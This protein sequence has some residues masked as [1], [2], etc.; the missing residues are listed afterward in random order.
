MFSYC[1]CNNK[2]LLKT[3]W[4]LALWNLTYLLHL[5]CRYMSLPA[6]CIAM[7]S[8]KHVKWRLA[9]WNL[10]S[11][12][13]VKCWRLL[14]SFSH[15]RIT[16][17]GYVTWKLVIQVTEG[18]GIAQVGMHAAKQEVRLCCDQKQKVIFLWR[19]SQKLVNSPLRLRMASSI[20][21]ANRCHNSAIFWVSLVSFVGIIACTASE[22][23]VYCCMC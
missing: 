13:Y 18:T 22:L 5:E 17:S 10:S 6:A 23:G 12:P 21:S 19:C 2:I 3:Y 20:V 16:N 7:V 14:N 9:L 11:L 8:L 15:V 1:K 4:S